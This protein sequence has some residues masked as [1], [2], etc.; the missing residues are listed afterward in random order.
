M[1]TILALMLGLLGGVE[2]D[3]TGLTIVPNL[4]RT[5]ILVSVEGAVEYRDFTME[6]PDRLILDVMNA[7]NA[8][9]GERFVG[10]NRGGVIAVR[11]S[12]YS[13]EVVRIVFELDQLVDYQVEHYDGY[14]RVSLANP[15][16]DF[17]P[18]DALTAPGAGATGTP[19]VTAAAATPTTAPATAPPTP[20]QVA[21]ERRITVSFDQTPIQDVLFTFAEFADR[22]IVPGASV[23]GFVTAEIRDQAWDDALN[24]I[25]R[26]QGLIAIEDENGIIRVDAIQNLNDQEAFA[27]LM[28]VPYRINF[29]TSTEVMASIQPLLS[30][31]GAVS[32]APANNTVIVT[33]IERV[34]EAVER[35]VRE[36]D[37]ATPQVMI[38]AKII[39]VNRT[40]LED[41]GLAYDL[42]DS[43][44]NQLNVLTPGF[45]DLDRDGEPEEVPVGTDV[46]SLGGNSI[47]ALGN[48][49][50][51]VAS[52]TLRLLS[53]LVIGRHTLLTFV[54]TLQ[55]MNLS[56]IQAAP[57]VTVAD[58]NQARLQVG[59]RTPIRVI[60]AG[61]AG[62]GQ[63]GFPQAT[64]NF[65]ETGIILT[66]T[67]HVTAGD[68]ILLDI[69]AERSAAQLAESDIGLIFQ[70]QNANTRVLVRDGET[71]VI[72][73]L[74]VTE[75]QEVRAG[76]PLLM[77]LPVL[78][79][80]F[81][82]TRQSEIQRDLMI[83]V[84][85]H[86]VRGDLN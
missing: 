13:P 66:A 30:E 20:P 69:R 22:S 19:A 8:L 12:Q 41:L 32:D 10:I 11:S 2:S 7:R 64:V 55:S 77:N 68:H 4:Q 84:T 62:G 44:G 83:L 34:H 31:R 35:L 24:T 23:A 71:V 5:E 21:P 47:A 9:P 33:D 57:S 25:L 1:T 60:D 73:G 27:P 72:G 17:E 86:I 39:F 3:V 80:L 50:N 63:G 59:E 85:P 29:G 53:S 75:R 36:L 52:P 67:P 46:I 61:S 82:T 28:T 48:A 54:E 14:I 45:A 16:G 37:V 74:T 70:T 26:S 81:R 51:R 56:D 15:W 78:G 76:I 6:G 65:E 58:N 49:Q 18:W 42:K 79:K 38:Q 40:D 43:Q